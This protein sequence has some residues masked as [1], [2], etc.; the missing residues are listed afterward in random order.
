MKWNNWREWLHVVDTDGGEFCSWRKISPP[1]SDENVVGKN[2]EKNTSVVDP[3][4]TTR[5]PPWGTTFFLFI[6]FSRKFDQ[7]IDLAP[8]LPLRLTSGK[9]W[10]CDC[11]FY[12]I[13]VWFNH[14]W[15][16]APECIMF[17]CL[18]ISSNVWIT[19]G[20]SS[21]MTNSR[22]LNQISLDVI[23][24]TDGNGFTFS[25]IDLKFHVNLA[26]FLHI[27]VIVDSWILLTFILLMTNILS[28]FL[29]YCNHWQYDPILLK[30][31]S[32]VFKLSLNSLN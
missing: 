32:L 7:I 27:N 29:L 31:L 26:N 1:E 10:F 3:R 15:S 30:S 12:I 2:V 13:L 21:W 5:T 28:I 22:L 16:I 17:Y 14:T 18:K 24:L 20:K 4:W 25:L 6:Q 9:S 19:E 23:F 11:N 8:S